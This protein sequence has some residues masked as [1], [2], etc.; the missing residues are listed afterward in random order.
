MFEEKKSQKVRKLKCDILLQNASL[1]VNF[2]KMG[3]QGTSPK[4]GNEEFSPK[5][6]KI[7]RKNQLYMGKSGNFLW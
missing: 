2:L 1:L 7:K 4:W 6:R 5:Q 3:I